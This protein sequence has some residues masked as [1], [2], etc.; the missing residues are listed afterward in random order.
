MQPQPSASYQGGEYVNVQVIPASG[1]EVYLPP[2]LS[3]SSWNGVSVVNMD[4]A[5][6]GHIPPPMGYIPPPMGY[7]PPPG[8]GY[9]PNQLVHP[10]PIQAQYPPVRVNHHCT[11]FLQ[12]VSPPEGGSGKDFDPDDFEVKYPPGMGPD[13]QGDCVKSTKVESGLN[14][15]APEFKPA[16]SGAEA[17]STDIEVRSATGV[18]A[19]ERKA[20]EKCKGPPHSTGNDPANSISVA[21]V[22]T[23][24]CLPSDDKTHSV[25][26]EAYRS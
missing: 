4:L 25:T 20:Q 13:S 9:V 15:L 26:V 12:T 3:Q 19:S 8:V 16:S 23:E 1:R 18:A 5:T 6:M 21:D 22:T 14:P 24:H 7:I 10:P 11:S 17:N 2:S